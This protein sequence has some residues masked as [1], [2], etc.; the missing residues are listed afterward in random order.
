MSLLRRRRF[1]RLSICLFLLVVIY[2]LF[3]VPGDHKNG[4]ESFHKLSHSID[5]EH[6]K[7]F[8]ELN[9]VVDGWGENGD[10]VVLTGEQQK[11]AD[12]IFSKAAFNVYT[13]FVYNCFFVI[14]F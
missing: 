13:R 7:L 6:L 8:Y 10:G 2:Y 9:P 5:S 1:I 4:N 12:K 11:I 3:Y 14:L